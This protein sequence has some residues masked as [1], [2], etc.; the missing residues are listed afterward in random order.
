M[1]RAA[2]A[3]LLLAALA[4]AAAVLLPAGAVAGPDQAQAPRV[5]LTAPI[6]G[7]LVRS[8]HVTFAWRV[9]WPRSLPVPAG[10][11]QVVHRYGSDRGLT[12][13]VTTTTRTCPASNLNCWAGFRPKSTFYGRYYWQVSVTGAVQAT[14]PTYL[15]SVGGSRP[16]LD[17]SRPFVRALDGSG[18]RGRA[19]VFLARV[20]DDSGEVR[21]QAELR[22]GGLQVVEGQT[23]FTAVVWGAK[24]RVRST[25]PLRRS[26]ARGLYRLCVTAWDRAGNHRQDCSRFRVR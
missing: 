6:N 3:V 4:V 25:R 11:V 24:Q 16:G 5:V 22:R 17:R 1:R 2:R 10:S 20:R 14:S 12:Q 8:S 21:L 9:E 18:R 26:L 19:A 13:Q 7:A 23:A 15:L